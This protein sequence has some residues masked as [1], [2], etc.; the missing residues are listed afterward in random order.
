MAT[1]RSSKPAKPDFFNSLL[2]VLKLESPNR[3]SVFLHDTPGK[4]AFERDNRALSHGCVR[5]QRIGELTALALGGDREEAAQRIEGAIASGATQR[6][7]L[8]ESLPVYFLYW[9]AIAGADGT[10]GFRRDLYGRDGKLMAALASR[11]TTPLMASQTCDNE[12]APG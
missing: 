12:T 5:V 4:T 10:V 7:A 9:T 2:G 6:L 3:Y 8:N 1:K 11:D